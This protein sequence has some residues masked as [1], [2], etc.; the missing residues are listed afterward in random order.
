[1]VENFRRATDEKAVEVSG[2]PLVRVIS[3][4]ALIAEKQTVSERLCRDTRKKSM[5]GGECDLRKE[6]AHKCSWSEWIVSVNF[7]EEK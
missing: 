4:R 2:M 6:V 5:V 7:K 1:M 3:D